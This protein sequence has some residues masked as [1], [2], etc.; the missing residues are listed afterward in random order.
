MLSNFVAAYKPITKRFS[1]PG[2]TNPII[3]LYDNDSGAKSIR[4][5]VLSNYRKKISGEESFVPVH[6]NLYLVAT[7]GR[8]SEIE[9]FFDD[10]T[11]STVVDG[12]RFN[13]EKAR[14]DPDEYYDKVVFARRVVARKAE[15]IDFTGFRPLL[16]RLVAVIQGHRGLRPL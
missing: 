13:A 5:A 16:Q 8:D 1:G 11:K 6:K 2:M 3:V 4:K 7:P 10:P 14:S 12:K 9:D 15:Q